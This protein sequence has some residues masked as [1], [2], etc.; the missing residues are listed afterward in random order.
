VHFKK[1]TN[2]AQGCHLLQRILHE[3]SSHHL[4]LMKSVGSHDISS[5]LFVI[6]VM[7]G[8]FVN[9]YHKLQLH[10]FSCQLE[11]VTV[12]ISKFLKKICD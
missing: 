3:D 11:I 5:L 10:S 9:D 7:V 1:I 8:H 4:K 6:K 2:H 12:D